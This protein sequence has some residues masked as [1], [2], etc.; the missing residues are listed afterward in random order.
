MFLY[1]HRHS[2]AQ[3]HGQLRSRVTELEQLILD[4]RQQLK[5]R[6]D[7]LDAARAA[8][9]DLIALASRQHAEPP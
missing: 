1:A 9:R 7:E 8:N 6:T 4:L 2:F 3:R 5:E